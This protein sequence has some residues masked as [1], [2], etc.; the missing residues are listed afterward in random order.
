MVCP[1]RIGMEQKDGFPTPTRG[2]P[3]DGQDVSGDTFCG[4]TPSGV[5]CSTID[6]AMRTRSKFE[7][8]LGKVVR[9]SAGRLR[10][11]S[12]EG[13]GDRSWAL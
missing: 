9:H 4:A 7:F 3:A 2:G 13:S 1:N 6:G 11:A 10:P 8:A 5:E 12:P